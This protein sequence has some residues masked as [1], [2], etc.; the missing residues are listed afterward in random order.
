MRIDDCFELGYIVKTHGLA[1]QVS[2][3]LDVD[4]PSQYYE[5]ESVFLEQSGH[6]VPFFFEHIHPQGNRIIARFDDINSKDNA[7]QLVGQKLFLPLDVLP[8]L[9]GK[10]Y[11]LHELVGM[12][13]FEGEKQLGEVSTIYQP[14]SQYL[15]A[16]ISEGKEILIPIE[17][18]IIIKV[19]KEQKKILVKLPDGFLD[20]YTS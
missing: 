8:S 18:D 19:D 12:A 6:L 2:I 17:N 1:G 13:V 5:M 7:S 10:E 14:S 16:V 11:Y 9:E 3:Q 20:I 15:A 4:D